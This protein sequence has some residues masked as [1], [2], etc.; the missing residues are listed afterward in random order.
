MITVI[1][2]GVKAAI[3]VSM[4]LMALAWRL[5]VALARGVALAGLVLREALESICWRLRRGRRKP[6]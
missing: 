2:A 3:L 6:A 1:R 5:V 4:V